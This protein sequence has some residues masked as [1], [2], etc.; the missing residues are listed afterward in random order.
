L[1]LALALA[2]SLA[3]SRSL[4]VRK[5]SAERADRVV[6]LGAPWL[7][8]AV[9][10]AREGK[11]S[12]ELTAALVAEGVSVIG[13][14]AELTDE[15][16]ALLRA[17]GVSLLWRTEQDP[18]LDVTSFL[19]RWKPGDA[20]LA[21]RSN[22]IGYP[23]QL[24]EVARALRIQLV[25]LPVLEFAGQKGL[26]TLAG[27]APE[28]VLK[29]HALMADEMLRP[30]PAVWASRLRRAVEE[31]WVRFLYVGMSPALSFQENLAFLRGVRSSLERDGFAIRPWNRDHPSAVFEALSASRA[32]DR[33]GAMGVISLSVLLP[34]ALLLLVR[35]T[36][37]DAPVPAFLALSVVSLL[38]G[39][40]LHVWGADE[41]VIAGIDLPRAIKLQLLGPLLVGAG[42]LF[43]KDE[44]IALLNAPVRWKH[45]VFVGGGL[46]AVLVLYVAR[47]GNSSLVPASGSELALREHL[48]AWFG[49]RP[50]FKEFGFGHPALILGLFLFK[51]DEPAVRVASRAL[52]LTGLIGQISLLNTFH[53]FQTP[54]AS[55]IWRSVHGLWLGVLVSIPLCWCAQRALAAR[56]AGRKA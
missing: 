44:L 39:V 33:W 1:A 46:A 38:G 12:A 45:L 52:V 21:Y 11:T 27:L 22:A 35:F 54:L 2:L 17:S 55:C 48:E 5:V 32:R 6:T 51:R 18:D 23:R 26:S 37:W 40:L 9:F 34:L 4:L 28:R 8:I 47:S 16:E 24:S 15:D 41:R 10:A 50:R 7:D 30:A 43:T 3:L 36:R 25:V 49:V 56:G 29:T 31:R 42:A 14:P 13:V 20:V 19:N 53:H